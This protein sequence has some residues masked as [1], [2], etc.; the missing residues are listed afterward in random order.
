MN[1]IPKG[2]QNIHTHAYVFIY[3]CYNTSYRYR[4]NLLAIYHNYL[5]SI[6]GILIL[7]VDEF[8]ELNLPIYKHVKIHLLPTPT[9]HDIIIKF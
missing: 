1:R 7:L 8:S 2:I 6:N 4:E 9:A 5:Q 3:R